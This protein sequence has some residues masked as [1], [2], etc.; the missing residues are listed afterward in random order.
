MSDAFQ[1]ARA[2]SA[3][4]SRSGYGLALT[5][6]EIP[7]F[8]PQKAKEAIFDI[9]FD[10]IRL[11]LQDLA[12]KIAATAPRNTG[13][14]A[15]SFGADPATQEGGI[16]LL[17]TKQGTGQVAGRVFSALP[18]AIVMEE[19]RRPGAP[20][21]RAGIDAIG[22]WAQRKLGLTAEEANDAKWAIATQIVAQGITGL[23][24]V[25]R[26]FASARPMY[27]AML[28]TLSED[29]ARALVERGGEA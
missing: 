28:G 24:Y 26:A 11:I 23:E 25:G 21:S 7:L 22:L 29:I 27:E 17:G 8:V 18:W 20:I 1:A 19:G 15:Q 6:P 14:L 5:I 10:T 2:L 13:H 12:G 3:A 16:E 4:S 9:V